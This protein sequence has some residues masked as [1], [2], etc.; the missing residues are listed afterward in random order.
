MI[1]QIGVLLLSLQ[2]ADVGLDITCANHVLFLEEC[3]NPTAEERGVGR[4][5]RLGQKKVV[6]EYRFIIQNSTEHHIRAR[7][8]RL[9]LALGLDS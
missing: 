1:V 6:N 7:K 9:T 5:H 3:W 2:A 8:V 4:A